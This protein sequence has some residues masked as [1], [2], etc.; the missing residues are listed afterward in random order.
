MVSLNKYAKQHQPKMHNTATQR[1]SKDKKVFLW[2]EEGS[3]V[4]EEEESY[5]TYKS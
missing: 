4:E 3:T 5:R 1:A 2:I